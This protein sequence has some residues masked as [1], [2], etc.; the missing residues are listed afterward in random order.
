VER[1][2]YRISEVAELIGVSKSKAYEMASR[3]ELPTIRLGGSLRVNASA[4]RA[5]L[6]KLGA[7]ASGA[8][9]SR[10]EPQ[11]AGAPTKGSQKRA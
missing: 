4:L 1:M 11:G 5:L 7:P 6:E 3:G 9:E 2:A 8:I 10:W